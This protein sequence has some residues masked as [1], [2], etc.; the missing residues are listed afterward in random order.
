L[1]HARQNTKPIQFL[2][3]KNILPLGV[4]RLYNMAPPLSNE[5]E[6]GRCLFLVKYFYFLQDRIYQYLM[7]RLRLAFSA[8]IE[9]WVLLGG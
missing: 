7:I 2:T 1:T 9:L 4:Y 3:C 6:A 8:M 5:P